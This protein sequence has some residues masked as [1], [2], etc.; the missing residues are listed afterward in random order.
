MVKN[1]AEYRAER[2]N[3]FQTRSSEYRAERTNKNIGFFEIK[4]QIHP[5]QETPLIP[6]NI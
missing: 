1:K 6:K 5:M 4:M 3:I 2:T